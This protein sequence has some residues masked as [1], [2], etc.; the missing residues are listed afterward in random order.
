MEVNVDVDC[1]FKKAEASCAAISPVTFPTAFSHF[2]EKR[3][4]SEDC[5]PFIDR[6]ALFCN[7][8]VAAENP[9]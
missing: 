7:V 4:Y 6:L 5:A 3:S 2:T 9:V 8:F 1:F